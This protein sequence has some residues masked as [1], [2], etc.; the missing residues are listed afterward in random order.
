MSWLDL[1]DDT[2]F[3]LDNLPYGVFSRGEADRQ[4]G[5]AVGEWVLDVHAVAEG[6]PLAALFEGGVLNPLM[7]AG[8]RTWQDVRGLVLEWLTEPR[9]AD[10]IRP[11]L[12]PV[13]D[14]TMRLPFEVADYVDFYSS[15]QHA[16]NASQIFRPDAAELP[17]NWKHLPIGYHGR[18][19]TVMVSG[20]PIVRP[21]G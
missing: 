15:E 10:L 12:V 4:V 7:A 18:A 11:H 5:V 13:A 21:N 19:G 3:G 17:P 16:L 6:T 1:A 20:T 9:H 14:V 2:L 8:R